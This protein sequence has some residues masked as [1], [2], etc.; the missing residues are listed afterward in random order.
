LRQQSRVFFSLWKG[1]EYRAQSR[2][3]SLFSL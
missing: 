3:L 1:G 2:G